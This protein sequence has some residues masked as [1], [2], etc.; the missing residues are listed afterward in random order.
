[1]TPTQV[2]HR[3]QTRRGASGA[4]LVCARALLTLHRLCLPPPLLTGLR[5]DRCQW[6]SERGE[7]V[8]AASR[9]CSRGAG[10]PSAVPDSPPAALPVPRG[11]R[12]AAP[13]IFGFPRESAVI[14]LATAPAAAGRFH[15]RA[16]HEGAA[17]RSCAKRAWVGQQRVPCL[18]GTAMCSRLAAQSTLDC[19][20]RA[21]RNMRISQPCCSTL[22]TSPPRTTGT[23]PGGWHCLLW[24]AWQRAR[25]SRNA[26][27][28]RV[29]CARW[30]PLHSAR[31]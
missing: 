21:T 10:L 11:P 20:L 14:A 12:H 23:V 31:T 27:P 28:F 25:C 18:S 17:G 8:V 9:L 5:D 29:P 1:M 16:Q 2:S 19:A 22:L 3:P 15:R 30:L 4:W 7:P 24:P 6:R 13:L 26:A